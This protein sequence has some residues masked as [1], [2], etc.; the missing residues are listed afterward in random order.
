ML[1][2][3]RKAHGFRTPLEDGRIIVPNHLALIS[4]GFCGVP[5]EIFIGKTLNDLSMDLFQHLELHESL[6]RGKEQIIE[7][8]VRKT[9][10]ANL[11]IRGKLF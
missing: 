7:K 5:P 2:H 3:S 8:K 1:D 4:C 6:H 10:T 9:F 11:K